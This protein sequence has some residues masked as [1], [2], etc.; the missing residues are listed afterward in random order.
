MQK[1]APFS[2]SLKLLHAISALA[3]G[4]RGLELTAAIQALPGYTSRGHGRGLPGKN[5]MRKARSKYLPH[6]GARECARR[7]KQLKGI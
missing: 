5:Y 2:R 3:A 4:L 7:L 6:Q 1:S